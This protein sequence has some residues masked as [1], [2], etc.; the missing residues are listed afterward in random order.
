MSCIFVESILCPLP[1]NGPWV[2]ESHIWNDQQ[3]I[4]QHVELEIPYISVAYD[5]SHVG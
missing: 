2:V 4:S 3:I 5:L 1:K